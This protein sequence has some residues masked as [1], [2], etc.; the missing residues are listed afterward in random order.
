M[1]LKT[2]DF[3]A[4]E[5]SNVTFNGE[6][7]ISDWGDLITMKPGLG[8]EESCENADLGA[9]VILANG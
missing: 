5:Q 8:T 7:V 6:I 4:R 3:S 9:D 1:E 2:N